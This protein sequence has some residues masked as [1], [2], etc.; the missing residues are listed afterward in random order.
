VKKEKDDD[1][2]YG[3]DDENDWKGWYM[4]DWVVRLSK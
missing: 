3:A 2:D 1:V 4:L